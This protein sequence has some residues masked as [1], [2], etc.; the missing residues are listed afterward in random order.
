V[1]AARGWARRIQIQSRRVA[2]CTRQTRAMSAKVAAE[3]GCRRTIRIEQ[4]IDECMPMTWGILRPYIVLPRSAEHWSDSRLRVGLAHEL[5]HVQRMDWLTQVGV[6]IV[7]SVYWF[8]PLFWMAA[9]RMH[10]ESES[11]CDDAVLHLG[12]DAR[13]YATHLLEIARGF[14]RS[15]TR[16]ALAMARPSDLEKRFAALLRSKMSREAISLRRLVLVGVVA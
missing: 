16:W 4:S 9:N 12:V 15:K 5:A 3:L 2:A 8:N 11:A 13:D 10:R 14:C 7:C 6:Q 1:F